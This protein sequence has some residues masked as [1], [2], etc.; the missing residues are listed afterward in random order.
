[1]L[2]L[3]KPYIDS[4]IKRFKIGKFTQLKQNHMVNKFIKSKEIK[5]N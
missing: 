5:K 1:M 2:D 4:I 3:F